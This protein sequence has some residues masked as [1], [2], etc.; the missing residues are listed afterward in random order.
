MNKAGR[1]LKS[2]KRIEKWEDKRKN[3]KSGDFYKLSGEIYKQIN[4]WF[5]KSGMS[6]E[7]FQ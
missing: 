6:M 5:L 2:H 1:G 3:Q 7:N 4:W